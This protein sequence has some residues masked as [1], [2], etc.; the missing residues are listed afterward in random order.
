MF[1]VPNK[2]V[3][4]LHRHTHSYLKYIGQIPA[5]YQIPRDRSS[6]RRT[7]PYGENDTLDATIDNLIIDT[8]SDIRDPVATVKNQEDT[9]FPNF[10]DFLEGDSNYQ[11]FP[12][13]EEGSFG[14]SEPL[15]NKTTCAT[16]TSLRTNLRFVATMATYRPWL[17]ID[18][19]A[20][21]G[22]QHLLPKH[23]KKILPKFDPDNDVTP[24]DHIKQFMLSLRLLDVQHEYVVCRLF[25]YTFVVQASTWFFSLD[26]GSIASWKQFETSFVNQFRDDRTS[27]MLV[28]ELSRMR[29]D[30]KDKIKDFNQRFLNLLNLIPEKQVESIQVEFYTTSLPPSIAMFV[31]AR[32]I[33][34]LAKKFIEAMQLEKDIA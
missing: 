2:E 26:V 9:K 27:G 18:V 17:S 4:Q 12:E 10:P 5:I 32:Q 22:P 13:A 3:N 24:K 33:R 31:K 6:I 34:T 20:V 29:C 28:L 23:P 25:P 15:E 19:V 8:I 30:K 14:P 21:P 1:L 16:P 11:D 7:E